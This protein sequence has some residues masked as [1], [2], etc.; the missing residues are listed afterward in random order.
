MKIQ[1]KFLI[2]SILITGIVACGSEP[3]SEMEEVLEDVEFV[4]YEELEAEGLELL[5]R[6]TFDEMDGEFY[7]YTDERIEDSY[8]YSY[9]EI[10]PD[11]WTGEDSNETM[12]IM[13]GI[14]G[15]NFSISY[16]MP[17]Y[18]GNVNVYYTADKEKLAASFSMVDGK[19]EGTARLYHPETG[20]IIVCR[21]YE[22]GICTDV[23][24]DV[25]EIMWRFDQSKSSLTCSNPDKHIEYINDTIKVLKLGPSNYEADGYYLSDIIEKKSFE[26]SFRVNDEPFTGRLIGYN[27]FQGY[28]M[29]EKWELNFKDGWLHDTI[30]VYDWWGELKLLE[31]FSFGDL[32]S[33]LYVMEE[34]YEDGVAKPIIY[35]YPEEETAITV[36]LKFDG[37]LTH[38]YPQYPGEGWSV[39]AE[40]DGTIHYEGREYYSLFWEGD[41]REE[42][43]MSEG[44]VIPGNETADFL[45]NSLSILG[46]TDKEANEFIIYWLPL[47]ENNNY[48]LIHFASKEYSEMA[49][50]KITP[51]PDALIRVMMV[52]SP[53]DE[54]IDIPQQNLYDLSA[55]RKGFTVVEWGGRKQE[56]KVEL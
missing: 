42:F 36:R 4:E 54:M 35:M 44:F 28:P 37:H 38:T 3:S 5:M 32:D 10:I 24:S 33:T 29:S 53:L 8:R 16:H 56:Y 23:T 46:L 11:L 40:S 22:Y 45:E 13:Q 30:K 41:A 39:V 25:Y 6:A 21:E 47:M 34:S 48:N 7:T 27:P 52:W 17:E 43:T 26:K 51:T 14:A 9:V 19:T 1:K 55:K 50:L 18:S 15:N 20:G 12:E 31:V 2:L 49:Q